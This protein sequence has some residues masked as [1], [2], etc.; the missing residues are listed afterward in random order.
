MQ[1][2]K[3]RKRREIFVEGFVIVQIAARDP[4][5]VFWAIADPSYE[6]F[7]VRLPDFL[8]I[9]NLVDEKFGVKIVID[10]ARFL[11]GASRPFRVVVLFE[12]LDVRS[13]EGREDVG[14][15]REVEGD[16]GGLFMYVDDEEGS[17]VPGHEFSDP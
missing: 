3:L 14:S 11:Q 6:I 9:N 1:S 4:L 15:V 8:V 2:E 12:R 13:V 16:R 10:G 5:I 17:V 7:D